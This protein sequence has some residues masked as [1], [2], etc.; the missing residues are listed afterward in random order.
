MNI[1]YKIYIMLFIFIIDFLAN[2][3]FDEC[4]TK[5]KG[6]KYIMLCFNIFIHS[7]IIS[8]TFCGWMFNN[9]FLLKC[10]ILLISL[11]GILWKVFENI[12]FFNEKSNACII[13]ILKNMLCNEKLTVSYKGISNYLNISPILY[14]F[15]ILCFIIISF[16]KI[17]YF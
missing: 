5:L 6:K 16:Y 14:N 3:K 1:T 12:N 7:I 11:I 13:S 4:F 8:I 9:K 17:Y 10:Y 2:Y 15:I